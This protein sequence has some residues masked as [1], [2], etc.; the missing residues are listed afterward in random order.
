MT[1]TIRT[2]V[3]VEVDAAIRS[4]AKALVDKFREAG[5]DVSWVAPE[6]LHLTLKFLGEI[7]EN[8]I[9]AVCQAVREAAAG[10]GPFA[11]E[12]RGAGAFPNLSRPRTVWLGAAEG[13]DA[14][15]TLAE[16]IESGLEK[17]GFRREGR[18]FRVHLTIGRV[19]RGGPAI[20]TL[21]AL[22]QDH[23]DAALGRTPVEQVVVFSSRLER[24]GA[25]HEALDW[26]ALGG[27]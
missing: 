12:I 20:A 4:A 5:A 15:A 13:E 21:G 19:R 10:V 27:G 23:A 22:L 9:P 11:L 6:N 25:V 24:T 8:R 3:A 18:R 26:A 16:R 7:N 1:Q 17:L 14:L 2:F